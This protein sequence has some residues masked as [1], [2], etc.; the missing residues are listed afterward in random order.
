MS[1]RKGILGRSELPFAQRLQIKRHAEI[2]AIRE[3]AAKAVMFCDCVALHD[4]EG[5]AYKRL[6]RYALHFKEIN[7]EF[8]ADPIVGMAH[9]KQR[10]AQHGIDISDEVFQLAGNDRRTEQR[11][12]ALEAGQIALICAAIAKNDVFGFAKERQDRVAA[13]THEL[14]MRY[15]DEGITFLLE[16]MARIGFTV[17]NGEVRCFVDD[18]GNALTPKK[19]KEYF[20]ERKV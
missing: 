5:I 18:D 9:A 2:V 12:H 11:N 7:D 20:A 4:I 16:E 6:T 15:S 1:K 14:T 3:Q 10:L 13:R 19:A 17:E 8:Y